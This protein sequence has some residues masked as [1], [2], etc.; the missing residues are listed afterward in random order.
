MGVE[1]PLVLLTL[2]VP[3]VLGMVARGLGIVLDRR[4]QA[5][6]ARNRDGVPVPPLARGL[7][8]R[9]RRDKALLPVHLASGGVNRS[10]GGWSAAEPA[11]AASGSLLSLVEAGWEAASWQ[12]AWHP[13]VADRRAP[14]WPSRHAG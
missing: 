1:T 14:A 12:P 10:I 4:R 7:P 3:S 13:A 8:P 5:R 6:V 11:R 9:C 2:P